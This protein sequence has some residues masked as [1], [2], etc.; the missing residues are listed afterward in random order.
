MDAYASIG[1]PIG[2]HHWSFG[3]HFLGHRE[4]LQARPDG[5]RLRD[6]DQLQSLH[7]LSDGRE[8]D[9]D[10]GAGDRPRLLRPQLAS[11]RATIC[12]APGPTPTRSSTTWCSRASTSPSARS[13]TATRRSSDLLDSCH[14]LMNYGVDRYKRP[15]NRSRRRR[16]GCA[17]RSARNTCSSRSTIC[18]APFPQRRGED[19]EQGRRS[20]S[21]PSRRRTCCTSSRRTRRCS[22]PGSARSCASCAR[23]PSTSIRSARPR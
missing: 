14:A 19:A 23:S 11:S 13:A 15:P 10:A 9:D 3:K 20:A 7:R 8:H 1:M 6:R 16:N 22:S 21:P 4:E 5:A 18:G 12:S 2:Y 17:R